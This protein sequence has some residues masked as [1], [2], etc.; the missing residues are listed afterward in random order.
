MPAPSFQDLWDDKSGKDGGSG[1][2]FSTTFPPFF[3]TLHHRDPIIIYNGNFC[4][5]F[6]KMFPIRYILIYKTFISFHHKPDVC[7]ILKAN[8]V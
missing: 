1:G 6:S 2:D 7:Q 5:R 4:N 8:F 3:P